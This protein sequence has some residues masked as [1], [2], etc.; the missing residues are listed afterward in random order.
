M[1]PHI[2]TAAS[3]ID[4]RAKVTGTARYAADFNVSGLAH[5]SVVTSTVARGRIVGIDTSAALRVAGVIDVLTHRNRPRMAS[6]DSAYKDEV[7]PD[8]APFRPLYDDKVLFSGQPVALVVAEE[9]ETARFAASLV[10]VDYDAQ[11]PV[12]DIHRRR[13]AATAAAKPGESMFAPPAA[14]GTAESAL[15]AAEVRHRGE[16]YVPI[17]HHNPMEPFASTVIWNGGGKLTVYDKTQ[18]VQNVQRYLCGVFE[19]QPDDV[20]VV[21]PFVGGAFGSGLRPQFQV[22][23]AVLAARALA[24]SVRVALTRQQMYVL[25]YRP[26]MI[27]RIE[28]GAAAGGR[29][30]AV[31][32]DATTVTSQY[33]DFYRQET[34]WSGLL[35]DCA[36]AR[37]AHKL[38]RLDLPTPCDMR[39][40]SAAPSVYALESAMDELAVA[41]GLDP[42]EL[43]LRCYSERDQTTGR[44]YSSKALRDCYRRGAEAFG[45]HRRHPEPRSMRDGRELV[46]WGMATGIWEALQV[47]I[48]VRITLSA[49]G[50]ADI[51]CAT[52]DIGTGTY[53]IMA[54]VAADM[55]G[56]PMDAVSI[57]LGDS[58]L[59]QSPVEGG[60][61]I[62]ASVSNGI[63]TTAD[64]VRTILLGLAKRVPNSPLA[65]ATP[66]EVALVDGKLSMRRDASRAVGIAD[67]MRHGGVD[68][69]EQEKTT[70]FVDD[71]RHAHNT[72]S[73]I[74]AE[75]KVDEELGIV[76]VTR[77]VNA[78]A[79]GRILNIKTAKSQIMGGVVWGIG[80]ALHEETLIDHK[81]GRFMNANMAD[82]HVPV[83]A[84][85]HDIEVIFVEE[86]DDDVNPLGI[87]GVGE[88]GIVGVAAAIAN[89][90]YH[91]TGKRVRDL[92]ITLDKLL[93]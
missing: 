15:A 1:A 90:V 36:N 87:K 52:S 59:P 66:E 31:E 44:P 54:Q 32:H 21:S 57:R 50:H 19:M 74:F 85:V 77:V 78:V 72:H 12:T 53:T 38:A 79:G 29:L 39:A 60:S 24:R 20:R 3:R 80:M 18:G 70:A 58:T 9:P 92:P 8:G 26:A 48:A 37:Y 22:V 55:L 41:L 88:I 89:A 30:D 7:A 68:R 13:D 43:R 67:A 33:E 45:W 61:W 27:Q 81:F 49:N 65:D 75:V 93:R 71:G 25:G 69:I 5:G 63:A 6:A 35:Y 4:G 11:A 17:E 28:L 73:A 47:P 2:G 83:N 86:P 46:G 40:P 56:L 34:G 42:L 84:D 10:R 23:L 91:A 76:R 82:Y 51:S 62:A 64:A 14:R 16:Y